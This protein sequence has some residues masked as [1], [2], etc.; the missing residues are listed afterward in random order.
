MSLPANFRWLL[1]IGILPRMITEG[2]KLLGIQE[3]PGPQS[4]PLILAFAKELSVSKIYTNDDQAWCA[5]AQNAVARRAGKRVTY[6]NPYDFLRALAF[7]KQGVN[8]NTNDWDVIQKDEAILGDTLIF[9]RETGGHLGLY[10]GEDA[11]HFY[12]MGGNQNNM[13]SFTRVAKYRLVA[14]RRPMYKIGK[15]PSAK[16]Y[17]VNSMGVPVTTNEQ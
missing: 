1:D 14:V 7:A 3:I 16:K 5:V 2:F 4:N 17:Q 10:I 6:A 12:V 11:T 15:P 9:K 8:F 13:Y